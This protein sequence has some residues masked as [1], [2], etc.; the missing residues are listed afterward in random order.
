[1][2]Q[3]IISEKFRG[4]FVKFQGSDEF[5][6][7]LNYFSTEKGQINLGRWFFLGRSDFNENEGV[8]SF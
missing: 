5:P 7:L 3:N 8:S 6:D 1:M 4:F 2:D